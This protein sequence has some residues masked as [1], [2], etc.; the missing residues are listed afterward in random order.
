MAFSRQYSL[1][2]QLMDQTASLLQH[3]LSFKCIN[4]TPASISHYSPTTD[5]SVT[6][7]Q[8]AISSSCTVSVTQNEFLRR[9]YAI[10]AYQTKHYLELEVGSHS[11]T[12]FSEAFVTALSRTHPCVYLFIIHGEARF[13]LACHRWSCCRP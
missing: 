7:S 3:L 6:P 11:A 1:G 9:H 2:N 4:K 8:S 10:A 12:A 13:T 5:T